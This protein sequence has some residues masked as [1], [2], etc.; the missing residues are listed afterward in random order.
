M[1]AEYGEAVVAEWGGSGGRVVSQW[2]QSCEA[3][4]LRRVE[5]QWWQSGEAVVQRRV[6]R[7]WWQS[8]EAVVAE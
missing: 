2:W 5:R 1:V 8:G 3:V 4:V 6:E 7:Q